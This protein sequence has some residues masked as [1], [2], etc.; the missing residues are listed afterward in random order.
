MRKKFDKQLKTLN[1]QIIEM[2]ALC[3]EAIML[4]F[5]ALSENNAGH[6]N[7]VTLLE[8]EIN[9]KEK[10]IENLCMKLLLRQQ[11]VAGDLRQISSALKM[12]SDIE[13]IG[14]QALDIAE[15]IPYLI[16]NEVKNK[17]HIEEMVREVLIMVNK[18]IDSHVHEDLDLAKQVIESDDIIDDYFDKVKKELIQMIAKDNQ[19]GDSYI[20][21]LMI[22][23]YLE[24]I[25]DHATNIAEWVVFSVTGVRSGNEV[26]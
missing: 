16:D 5:K 23:K 3:E 11:P 20:D 8:Q 22:A 19:Y 7:K 12:I 21:L 17:T 10:D 18:S 25:G 4:D 15:I 14:D 1:D 2:G 6:L 9:Q 24:R 13:R 26:K